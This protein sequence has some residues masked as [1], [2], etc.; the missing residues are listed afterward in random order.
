MEIIEEAR[1]GILGKVGFTLVLIIK[2]FQISFPAGVAVVVVGLFSNVVIV[3]G[4][5]GELKADPER[6]D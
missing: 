5:G 2:Q 6:V 4:D 3:S 1:N